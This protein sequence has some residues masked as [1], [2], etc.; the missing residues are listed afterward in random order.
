MPNYNPI[1]V[2]NAFLERSF[3]DGKSISPMKLQKLVFLAHGYYLGAKGQPLVE[4]EFQAWPYGPVS[5]SLYREFK[6]FG[7]GPITQ[8]G[9]EVCFTDDEEFDYRPVATPE[10]EFAQRVISFVWDKYKDWKATELSDLSHQSGWAWERVRKRNPGQRSIDI[11]NLDI[12][13]DFESLVTKKAGS[14]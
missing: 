8:L 6:Q 2:A 3:D 5:Q 10:D 7:G 12:K 11:P 13:T 1:A 4:E 9:T 14:E